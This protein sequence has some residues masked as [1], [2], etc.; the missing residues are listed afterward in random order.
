MVCTGNSSDVDKSSSSVHRVISPDDRD[1]NDQYVSIS[2][3][4]PT[5]IIDNSVCICPQ[6]RC[7]FVLPDFKKLQFEFQ[8]TSLM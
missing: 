8:F 2:E 7:F 5:L 6:C 1:Y 3:S 4:V